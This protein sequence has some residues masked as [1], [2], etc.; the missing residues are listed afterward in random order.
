VL[1]LVDGVRLQSGRGHGAQTSLVSVDKLESVELLPGAG[2]A[3]YGSDALGGCGRAEHALQPAHPALGHGHADRAARR[4]PG[5]ENSAMG[6]LRYTSPGFGAEVSAGAGGLDALV[7]P[8]GAYPTAATTSTRSRAARL[9]RGW[10]PRG[11]TS[12][13][14]STR[15]RDIQLPA[16]NSAAGSHAEFPLQGRDV[17]GSSG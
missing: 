8:D 7:T 11:S 2:G 3:V 13:T 12:S 14:R 10:A 6:R 4:P 17:N 1:V 16:F 5:E 15:A 9:M